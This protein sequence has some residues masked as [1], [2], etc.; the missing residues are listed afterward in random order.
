MVIGAMSS[1]LPAAT[2]EDVRSEIIETV[3]RLVAREVI[4]VASDLERSDT[5]PEAIVEHMRALGL[6]GVTIP[7]EY[8]GLGLDLLTY[9]GVIEELAYGWMSLTG[10]I[11]THTMAATLIMAHRNEEQKQRWLPVLASGDRRGALSLSEPDAGSDTRNIPCRA[12]R[13]GDE[14]VVNGTKAWVTNGE[15]SSLVALAA[16]TDEG[17]SAFIVEKEPGSGFEGIS[18]TK[19]VSKLGY[20]GVETVEMSYVDH[21]IPAANLIG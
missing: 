7:E 1:P 11:N 6:F 21:R 3:R 17:I 15:R 13:D 10:I 5:Y 9:I 16:R 14:Y 19:H 12:T 4:P 2:D 18:V 20:R 8:G